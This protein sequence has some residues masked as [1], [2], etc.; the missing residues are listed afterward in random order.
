VKPFPHWPATAGLHVSE[1]QLRPMPSVRHTPVE[2]SC[3]DVQNRHMSG[4]P[5]CGRQ[6]NPLVEAWQLK[7]VGQVGA[8][9]LAQSLVQIRFWPPGAPSHTSGF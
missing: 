3:P 1:H 4:V 8:P 6:A 5:I 2:Q 7:P 9:A